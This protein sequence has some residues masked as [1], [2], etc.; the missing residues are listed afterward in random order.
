MEISDGEQ[1]AGAN[2][3]SLELVSPEEIEAVAVYV[4]QKSD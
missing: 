2:F 4:S 3:G 1:T